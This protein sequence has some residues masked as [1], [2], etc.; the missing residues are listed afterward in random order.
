MLENCPYKC[1]NFMRC[2]NFI[3]SWLTLCNGG[4]M[5]V[6]WHQ[7]PFNLLYQFIIQQIK[8]IVCLLVFFTL[9][10]GLQFVFRRSL[11]LIYNI[12][13][14]DCFSQMFCVG[15]LMNGFERVD[16]VVDLKVN[17]LRSRQWCIENGVACNGADIGVLSLTIVDDLISTIIV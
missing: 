2:V 3:Q 14:V 13:Q 11:L 12:G 5:V 15:S 16:Q 1:D 10:V 17:R 8:I 7:Y 4:V 9:W 6:Q